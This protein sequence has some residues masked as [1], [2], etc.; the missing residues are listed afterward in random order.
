MLAAQA[1]AVGGVE[2]SAPPSFSSTTWFPPAASRPLADAAGAGDHEL[3]PDAML[4]RQI[5]QG[6]A[7]FSGGLAQRT[8]ARGSIGPS[9]RT[10]VSSQVESS[11]DQASWTSSRP[12]RPIGAGRPGGGFFSGLNCP[13]RKSGDLLSFGVL[14]EFREVSREGGP[15]SANSPFDAKDWN[16][17]F[18][19]Q[20]PDDRER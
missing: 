7:V 19:D 18:V 8:R 5:P 12:R 3:A 6:S 2:P 13:L 9:L 4:S 10:G 17:F 14:V 15:S 11:R 16:G 1:F 20:A